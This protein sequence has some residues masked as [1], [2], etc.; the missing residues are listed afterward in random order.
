MIMP[1]ENHRTGNINCR[2]GSGDQP[3]DHSRR[4]IMDHRPPEEEENQ[5]DHHHRPGG[6]DR[7]SKGLVYAD[8]EN[9]FET[10]LSHLLDILPD[11]V[12]DDDCIVDRESDDRQDDGEK[13]QRK[14]QTRNGDGAKSNK[15]IMDQCDNAPEAIRNLAESESHIDEDA[16]EG[17]N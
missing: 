7:P 11:P 12:K 10:L 4:K 2:I 6:E 16:H 14:F 13:R 17:Q 3:D 1:E 9:R 8:I 15:Y 5:N